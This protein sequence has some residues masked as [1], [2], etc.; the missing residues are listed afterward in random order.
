MFGS[1]ATSGSD[2]LKGDYLSGIVGMSS[3]LT[4]LLGTYGSVKLMYQNEEVDPRVFDTSYDEISQALKNSGLS[5]ERREALEHLRGDIEN[6]Q[7]ALEKVHESADYVRQ[8]FKK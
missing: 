7:S 1:S 2:P 3:K 8:S 4:E 5:A 6:L